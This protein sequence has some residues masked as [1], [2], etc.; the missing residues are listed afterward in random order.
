MDNNILALKP[1]QPHPIE[2]ISTKICQILDTQKPESPDHAH[3]PHIE[4]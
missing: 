1:Y 3:E 4:I 2:Q